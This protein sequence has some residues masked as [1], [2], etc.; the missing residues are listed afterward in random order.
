[1]SRNTCGDKGLF[2]GRTQVDVCFACCGVA[3]HD[4]IKVKFRIGKSFHHLFAHFKAIL[5]DAGAHG[6]LNAIGM[7]S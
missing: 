7:S 6:N 1:M 3:F 5:A 2:I 4:L